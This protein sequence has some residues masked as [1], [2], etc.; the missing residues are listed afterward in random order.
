MTLTKGS[1]GELKA[2]ELSKEVTGMIENLGGKIEDN[3]YWGKRKLAYQIKQETDGFYE[4]FTFELSK[5]K[6]GDLQKNLKMKD[7]LVRYLITAKS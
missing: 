3:D 6:I 4:I 7:N 2:K 1:Q 5:D